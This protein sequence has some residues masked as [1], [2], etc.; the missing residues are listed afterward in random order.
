MNYDELCTLVLREFEAEGLQRAPMQAVA[1][2]GIQERSK[3]FML[4]VGLP[5]RRILELSLCLNR[6]HL[7]FL[8]SVTSPVGNLEPY[9]Q[10]R[11]IGKDTDSVICIDESTGGTI[12]LID[13]TGHDQV[14]FVNSRVEFFGAGLA[15][16]HEYCRIG[17]TVAEQDIDKYLLSIEY[18]LRDIDAAALASPDTWWAL[19][20]EQMKDG[21]L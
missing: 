15:L 20:V 2:I 12:I 4:D 13:L 16:Y 17:P 3:R 5:S 14:R 19:I 21:L 8:S 6:G 9:A 10:A 1:D 11:C 18:R 7:P